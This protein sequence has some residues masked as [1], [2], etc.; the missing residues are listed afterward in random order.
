MV[1]A[2]RTGRAVAVERTGPPAG[3][4]AA[5]SPGWPGQRPAANDVRVGMRHRLP[6]RPAGVEHDAVSRLGDFLSHRN[7]MRLACHLLKEAAA[8]FRDCR[9]LR[10]MFFRYNQT[11]MGACGL[12]SRKEIVRAL[13]RTRL[14]G[15]S[16][17]AIPQNRQSATLSLYRLTPEDRGVS[18]LM[19]RYV[20]FRTNVMTTHLL[21]FNHLS[22]CLIPRCIDTLG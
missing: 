11:C 1:A 9:K 16:P 14:A 15:M 21:P 3:T 10:V 5:T 2:R 22:G 7:A 12:I 20:R 6:G 18:R 17:S 4:R 13:S 19:S 8:S